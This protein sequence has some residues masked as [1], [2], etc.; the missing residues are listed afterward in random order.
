VAMDRL[1][2]WLPANIPPAT[3]PRSC[4]ATIASRT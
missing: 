4:T 2:E 1:M 3:T